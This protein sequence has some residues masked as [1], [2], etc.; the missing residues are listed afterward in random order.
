MA[1][2]RL[3]SLYCSK[4]AY[5]SCFPTKKLARLT[6]TKNILSNDSFELSARLSLLQAVFYWKKNTAES[7]TLCAA[8]RSKT[9][10]WKQDSAMERVLLV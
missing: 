9:A 3:R 2:S 10:P 6:Q 7:P 5:T 4:G 8:K 1:V